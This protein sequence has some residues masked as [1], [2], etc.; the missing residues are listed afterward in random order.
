MPFAASPSHH[1]GGI[2]CLASHSPA[3][4]RNCWRAAWPQESWSFLIG[5]NTSLSVWWLFGDVSW[6]HV[7]IW[8]YVITIWSTYHCYWLYWQLKTMSI[9]NND[10]QLWLQ[11]WW[12]ETPN[13]RGIFWGRDVVSDHGIRME[14]PHPQRDVREDIHLS[15]PRSRDGLT[16]HVA[17]VEL[18]ISSESRNLNLLETKQNDQVEWS[19]SMIRSMT[20]TQ[21]MPNLSNSPNLRGPQPQILQTPVQSLTGEHGNV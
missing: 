8:W 7:M 11:E 1:W 20:E 3:P 9:A 21:M 16:G 14:R 17:H 13:S 10:D 15:Q 18:Y 4:G 5:I 12:S 19:N 6:W 2:V